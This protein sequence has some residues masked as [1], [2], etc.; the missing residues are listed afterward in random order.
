M[1]YETTAPDEPIRQGDIFRHIPRVD[2]SL[3]NLAVLEDDN[4]REASWRDFALGSVVTAV[5]SIKSVSG[6][7]LTQDCDARRGEYLY[8]CQV[9]PFLEVLRQDASPRSSRKWMKL[10]MDHARTNH[11]LFYLPPDE[12]AGFAERMVADFRVVIRVSRVDLEELKGNRM[13]RL[14]EVALSHFRESFS[15]FFRRHAYNEWYPLTRDEYDAYAADCSLEIFWALNL[16][17]N[18]AEWLAKH[19]PDRRFSSPA[20]AVAKARAGE[21]AGLVTVPD[22]AGSEACLLGHDDDA[23]AGRWD[24]RSE[25]YDTYWE[26]KER[27]EKQKLLQLGVVSEE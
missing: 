23:W 24:H 22:L 4:T 27:E 8:L 13:A 19:Y 7:V 2:L 25:D 10:I 17:H 5:L 12:R 1:I 11:R 16:R 14:N 26:R 20:K 6:I 15:H 9:D 21:V 3:D 18:L